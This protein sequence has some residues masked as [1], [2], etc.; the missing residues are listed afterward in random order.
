M[1]AQVQPSWI[2]SAGAHLVKRTYGDAEW[3]AQRGMASR[4]RQSRFMAAC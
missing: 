2:E 1:V 3:D 4:A